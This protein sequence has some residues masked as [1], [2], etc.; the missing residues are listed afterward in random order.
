M[1]VEEDSEIGLTNQVV[2]MSIGFSWF[3]IGISGGFL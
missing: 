1:Y 2:A 3:R